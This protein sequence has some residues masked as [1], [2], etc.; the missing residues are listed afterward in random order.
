[1]NS[2]QGLK[3]RGSFSGKRYLQLE[4]MFGQTVSVG[5]AYL[6]YHSLQ[7]KDGVITH[8]SLVVY[9]TVYTPIKRVPHQPVSS[10][11]DEGVSNSQL[12]IFA[13]LKIHPKAVA[14]SKRALKVQLRTENK[15]SF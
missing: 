12:M 10:S 15:G 8:H 11:R 4:K 14:I 3:I 5:G 2:G 7:A 9:S 1:M 13:V 6:S